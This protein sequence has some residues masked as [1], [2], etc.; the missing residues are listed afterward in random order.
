MRCKTL[1]VN[2]LMNKIIPIEL[3][4]NIRLFLVPLFFSHH[5]FNEK[6]K[7]FINKEMNRRALSY[8]L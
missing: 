3:Q 6:K 7:I 8:Y 1:T 2:I 4:P 5:I